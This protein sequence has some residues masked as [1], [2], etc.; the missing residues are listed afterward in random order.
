MHRKSSFRLKGN[1]RVERKIINDKIK[2]EEERKGEIL[3]DDPRHD[4]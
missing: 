4:R 2:D 3:S 1:Q